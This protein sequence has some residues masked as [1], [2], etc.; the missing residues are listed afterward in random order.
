MFLV[1][2]DY[3]DHASTPP[4]PAGDRPWPVRP[5]PFSSY[6]SGFEVRTYRRVQRLLFFNNFPGEPTAGRESPGPVAR[7]R[8][9][10][11]AGAGRPARPELH[12]PRLGHRDRLPAGAGGLVTRSMPPLE[13]DYSE[14]VIGQQVLTLDPGSQANL[15]EGLD[16][17]TYRWTDLDGEG[18]SGDP[19]RRPA[20]PGT[21]SGTAAP[22]TS[23]RSPT[24]R[25]VARAS[26]GPLETVAALPSRSR[27]VRRPAAGP[28][29]QRP[30]R[31]RRPVR[32]RRRLL[33]ADRRRRTSSRCTGSRRC[34]S[35][36]GPIRT[37]RSST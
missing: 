6:R 27:P 29:R 25:S 2:L 18:L 36:T 15:P 11:P 35:W 28:V 23:S 4:A 21:T 10:R 19:E 9:L 33:R 14:P 24:G 16:G 8:L 5:D 32:A 34:R 20:A 12:V 22:A 30:P 3:G 37:S 1:V 17:R 26:F 7:S 31:R 13:F